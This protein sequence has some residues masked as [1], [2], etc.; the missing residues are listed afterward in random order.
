MILRLRKRKLFS[1]YVKERIRRLLRKSDSVKKKRQSARGSADCRLERRPQ[2]FSRTPEPSTI[3]ESK[4]SVKR[5]KNTIG[6]L[7]R[8]SSGTRIDG[9]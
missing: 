8:I 2:R 6:S 7:R 3:V 4:W 9:S 1:S 5:K